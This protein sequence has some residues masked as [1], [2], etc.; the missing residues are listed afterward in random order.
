VAFLKIG[1]VGD[2]VPG[3]SR[4]VELD[5]TAILVANLDGTLHAIAN[6]CP[7]AKGDL[8]RGLIREG[9]VTCPKHGSRFDLRTGRNVGPAKFLFIK[10]PVKDARTFAVRVEGTEVLVEI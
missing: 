4:K 7:H 1:S 2:F 6:T 3:S 10:V 9:I 8:S 5:G